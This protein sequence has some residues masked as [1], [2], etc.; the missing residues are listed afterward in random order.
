MESEDGKLKIQD[1]DLIAF[2]KQGDKSAPVRF[3]YIDKTIVVNHDTKE[4]V[5]IRAHPT[6]AGFNLY[7][8]N[9]H[10]Y[11]IENL[12]DKKVHIILSRDFE[13]ALVTKKHNEGDLKVINEEEWKW[14]AVHNVE[15]RCW[16][17]FEADTALNQ[18]AHQEALDSCACDKLR[19]LPP[20]Y[21]LYHNTAAW[22]G[23]L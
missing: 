6:T 9:L 5:G 14:F 13:V 15:L 7:S 3:G 21:F 16:A 18:M 4:V 1:T 11:N 12:I 2:R 8:S 23:G 17:C 22:I 19:I 20:T 10:Y